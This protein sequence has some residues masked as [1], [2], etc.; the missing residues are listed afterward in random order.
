MNSCIIIT[1]Y[2]SNPSKQQTAVELLDFLKDKNLPII[3][4]GNYKI[5]EEIQEKS[6][7]A[8][9]TKENP[10]INRYM[11]VWQQLPFQPQFKSFYYIKDY[12]YAH[13][14]QAYRGFKL[15]E[16]LGYDHAI[17]INYDIDL[18]EERFENLLKQIDISPNL[19][20]PWTSEGCA[21]NFYC[22]TVEDFT[23]TMETTLPFYINNNPP[24]I[25][26]G[27]YCEIFLKWA[28]DYTN[29]KY[30]L[31]D[32]KFPDKV[33]G[34]CFYINN[35]SFKLYGWEENNEMVLWFEDGLPNP[36]D[37]VFNINGK[38][39]KAVPTTSPPHFILPF[40]RGDYYDNSGKFIF[41]LDDIQLSKMKILPMD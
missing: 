17:H 25:K 41:T 15:A 29:T 22:L 5:P 9:Y 2:L 31:F 13:L 40:E 11:H 8:L 39:L 4:V 18:N 33:S 35:S 21:T 7:W 10:E 6:D 34:D 26:E 20:T 30:T 23:S 16:S 36:E 19:I 12:G 3:F 24:D 32:T 37:L 38:S 28:L 27:W 14:L 1:S